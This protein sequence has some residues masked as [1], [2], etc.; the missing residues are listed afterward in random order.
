MTSYSFYSEQFFKKPITEVFDFFKRPE[1]LDAIT[2]A[3]LGFKILTPGPILMQKNAIIDYTIR[4]YGV[5]MRW[6]TQITDYHPPYSFTDTQVKGP[7]KTWIHTH[8]FSEKDG[9][10]LMT[11]NVQYSLFWGPVG[12]IARVLFV[13]REIEKIFQARRQVLEKIF[14]EKKA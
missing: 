3:K 8:T 6:Q 14:T 7:Y 13:K 4:L 11:D 5:P 9:G 2:P 12:E 1:N 10:T